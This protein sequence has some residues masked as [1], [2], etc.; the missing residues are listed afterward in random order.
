MRSLCTVSPTVAAALT[1]ASCGGGSAP[2][3]T[4]S[5]SPAPAPSPSPAPIPPPSGPTLTSRS[6]DTGTASVAVPLTNSQGVA[7]ADVPVSLHSEDNRLYAT[8]WEDNGQVVKFERSGASVASGATLAGRG[9]PLLAVYVESA[10]QRRIKARESTDG[11]GTRSSEVDLGAAPD[12]PALPTACIWQQGGL[13]RRASLGAT[14]R[15]RARG[16]W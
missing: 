16:R 6:L 15:R 7:L 5:P 14:S 3:T 8:R 12:G 4:P 11:G 2:A 9:N 13:L 1:L 10:P